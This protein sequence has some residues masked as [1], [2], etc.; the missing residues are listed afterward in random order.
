MSQLN[1]A[2]SQVN[3]LTSSGSTISIPKNISVTGNINFTGDLL[4]N[5]VLFETLPT[6][7][8]K[9]AGGILM[10][11]GAN[12]FWGSAV[13]DESTQAA[14]QNSYGTNQFGPYKT[15]T[16]SVNAQNPSVSSGNYKPYSG[17]GQ[18][19]DYQVSTYNITIGSSFLYRSIFTHGYL[20]G[21]Y[22]GSNPW[23]TVNQIYQA[24]DVTICRGDQLDRAASY[25]DGNFGDFN[26]Y[27]YGTQ[28]SYGGSG[29]AVSAINLHTGT[30]RS[31]G[32]NGTYGHGD[33]YN[34]TPDSIG[35]S[36]DS[37]DSTDDPGC[38]SGQQ[39][40]RGYTAGGGPGSIQRLNFVT[41][42]STRLGNG[43][44]NSGATGSEG[45][46]RCHLFGDTG[47]ARYVQFS[48]ESVSSYS[49]S[50]WGGDGWKKDLSTKWGSCYHGNG[51]NVTLLWLTFNDVTTSSIGGA[52]NQLDISSGEENM[53]MGQDWG[54]CLGNYAG[55][56]GGY[57]N[58]RTWKRF[59]A[60]DGDV[61]L[62]FKAEPKGHQG[63]SSGACMT[64]AFAVT[65][66]RYQ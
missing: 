61:V 56:G 2:T 17:T 27:V 30:N 66:L 23:R 62:G 50:G 33:A 38:A 65:G 20:V 36:I 44:G 16:G 10:S 42:M 45:E 1:A 34:S 35:A 21:G 48:N 9:T 25:V 15:D 46:T 28:N 60:T 11:D 55:G 12:A 19:Y 57:Q 54:Y 31:F 40:Q 39:T 53:C 58:N 63:Q 14:F 49:L 8:P 29:Q 47:N 37:W 43:F 5:G 18:W 7:S 52:F 59:H 24:T 4:Q 22:R 51:N 41:E 3:T 13:A 26:G 6:Q 64:G 32:P